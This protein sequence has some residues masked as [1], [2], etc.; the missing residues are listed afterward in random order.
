MGK[1]LSKTITLIIDKYG[2]YLLQRYNQIFSHLQNEEYSLQQMKTHIDEYAQYLYT[3]KML[4]LKRMSTTIREQN[5]SYSKQIYDLRVSQNTVPQELLSK[6]KLTYFQAAMLESAIR[7]KEID[8][9][10]NDY[11]IDKDLLDYPV[12]TVRGPYSDKL[13]TLKQHDGSIRTKRKGFKSTYYINKNGVFL[14]PFDGR[15]LIGLGKMWELKGRERQFEFTFNELSKVVH[16]N[17]QGGDYNLLAESIVNIAATSIVLDEFKDD[18]DDYEKAVTHIHSPISEAVV[19]REQRQVKILFSERM[20]S[21]L[22]SGKVVNL[23]MTLFNDLGTETSKILYLTLIQKAKDG[24][25]LIETKQLFEQLGLNGS[26]SYKNLQTLKSAIEE[27]CAYDVVYDYSF[28]KK[29]R[30]TTHLNFSLSDWVLAHNNIASHN[31]TY[32]E[33]PVLF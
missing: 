19:D 27:L 7:Y 26:T 32:L 24:H 22:L 3:R 4:E 23:S 16:A 1:Q 28:L 9:K 11:S 29:G 5:L 6:E 25:F 33:E 21:N 15:T 14:S 8:Q 13:D 17:N 20:H 31:P 18:N 12:M 10:K 2:N 30:V